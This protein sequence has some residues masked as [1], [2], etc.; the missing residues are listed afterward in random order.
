MLAVRSL[1]NA[2]ANLR[3]AIDTVAFFFIIWDYP[4]WG[5]GK[6]VYAC[7]KKENVSI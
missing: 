7:F 5:G 4:L 1:A 3:Y 2:V 6:N